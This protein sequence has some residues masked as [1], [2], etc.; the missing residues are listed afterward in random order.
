M[1]S[2]STGADSVHITFEFRA[3]GDDVLKNPALVIT[4][5]YDW[6]AQNNP[7]YPIFVFHDGQKRQYI[8]YSSAN[9]AINRAA[10]YACSSVGSPGGTPG[11]PRRLVAVLAN[12]GRVPF[13]L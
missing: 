8:T 3:P 11:Q 5:L 13:Q 4:E 12:T 2:V 1:A 9:E 10:R 7:N 6:N